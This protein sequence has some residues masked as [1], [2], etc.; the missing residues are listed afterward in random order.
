MLSKLILSV[1]VA[2]VV[3][4]VCILLGA[5]LIALKVDIA[6]TVGNFLKNYGGCFRRASR[7]LVLLHWGYL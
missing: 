1:V 2:V 6:V 4:L 7:P 5:I 3:T